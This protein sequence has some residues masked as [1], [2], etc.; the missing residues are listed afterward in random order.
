MTRKCILFGA[1]GSLGSAILERLGDQA[2]PADWRKLTDP[3]LH[4]TSPC[5]FI[6]ANGLTDPS[7]TIEELRAANVDF[8]LRVI[9]A[10]EGLNTSGNRYLTLGSINENFP[11]L[12]KSNMYL[13]SKLE[14]SKK[15]L[16]CE[17]SQTG[18][19]RFLHLRIHTAYGSTPK[20]YM[21][22]G[23]ILSSLR[24]NKTFEMSSGDQ[25]REYHHQEDIAQAVENILRREWDFGPTLELNSGEPVRLADL[26]KAIFQAFKAEKFLHIGAIPRHESENTDRHFE[27]SPPWL[28]PRGRNTIESVISSLK[29]ALL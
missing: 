21:F 9:E 1:T 8:P 2:A 20:P 19:G 3:V 6:F 28:L 14:L 18:K 22:L 29:T 4:P 5:D 11:E 7:K 16:A 13:A 26:A 17:S 24:E 10:S 15:M 25:L 27:P 23:Q 12:C